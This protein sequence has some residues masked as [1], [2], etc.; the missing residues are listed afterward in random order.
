M[1]TVSARKTPPFSWEKVYEAAVLEPDNAR[2]EKCVA[3]VERLLMSRLL[4]LTDGRK[5]RDEI[6]AVTQALSSLWKLRKERLRK[7][8]AA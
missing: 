8:R 5:H 7:R 4:E 2:L 1:T 3:V 6:A